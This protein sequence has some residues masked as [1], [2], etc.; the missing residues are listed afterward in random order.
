MGKLEDDLVEFA[1]EGA[2][3]EFGELGGVDVWVF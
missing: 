1:F 2:F 3:A